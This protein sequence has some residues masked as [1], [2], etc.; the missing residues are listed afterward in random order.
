MAMFRRV[1]CGVGAVNLRTQLRQLSSCRLWFVP[2]LSLLVQSAFGAPFYDYKIIAKTGD[3][4]G[5]SGYTFHS[6]KPNPTMNDNGRITFIGALQQSPGVKVGEGVCQYDNGAVS[7]I[8]A[9]SDVGANKEFGSVWLNNQNQLATTFLVSGNP[10]VDA[11]RRYSGTGSGYDVI[12]RAGAARD[13]FGNPRYPFDNLYKNLSMNNAGAMA[14]S[15]LVSFTTHTG[16]TNTAAAGKLTFSGVVD[17]YPAIDDYGRVVL[18]SGSQ[19][20]S[21]ILLWNPGFASSEPI[22]TGASGFTRMGQSPGVTDTGGVVAFYAED[23]IGPG[24]FVSTNTGG[25]RMRQPIVRVTD[26]F[27]S[28]TPDTRVAIAATPCSLNALTVVYSATSNG[29]VGLYAIDLNLSGNSA[30]PFLAWPNRWVARA[31]DTIRDSAGS[32]LAGTVQ[33]IAINDPINNQGEMV[34]WLRTTAEIEAIVLASPKVN[35]F[36]QGAAEVPPLDPGVP[37]TFG[38]DLDAA[39]IAKLNREQNC[40]IRGTG[41]AST[42]SFGCTLCSV[43]TMLTT[44]GLQVDP[45]RLDA[46]LVGRNGY[47]C[48]ALLIPETIPKLFTCLEYRGED[49][50]LQN[51]DVFFQEQLCRRHN[52]VIV[53]LR[54]VG[55]DYRA[56]L[57]NLRPRTSRPNESCRPDF[58]QRTPE[59]LQRPK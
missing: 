54:H 33:S 8:S 36:S 20:N 39:I 29:R 43:A 42:R 14:F 10:T 32:T 18:R 34:L 48:R 5:A 30:A 52:R 25:G 44:F 23:T 49:L 7:L 21:P 9:L 53:Q 6:F 46:M 16:L 38:M 51:F 45:K 57:A 28:L 12:A 59:R 26:N 58:A 41:K 13:P 31:G 56:G 3:P 11:V 40:M 4:V 37:P 35:G 22:A 2:V 27:T 19:P 15:G 1:Q 50:T 47:G 24:I 55:D 17:L